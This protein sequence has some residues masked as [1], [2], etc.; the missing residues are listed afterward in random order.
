[1]ISTKELI[2]SIGMFGLLNI[3][4]NG[5]GLGLVQTLTYKRIITDKFDLDNDKALNTSFTRRYN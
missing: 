2:L 5:Y 1:M 3:T 4:A